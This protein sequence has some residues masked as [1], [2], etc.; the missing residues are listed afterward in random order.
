MNSD[1]KKAVIL[2][3]F[4]LIICWPFAVLFILSFFVE[5]LLGN[6]SS[7]FSMKHTGYEDSYDTHSIK[8]KHGSSSLLLMNKPGTTSYDL[9]NP[10]SPRNRR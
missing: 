3:S 6:N 7:L 5:R 4:W 2:I 8:M 9:Y 10:C 1:L